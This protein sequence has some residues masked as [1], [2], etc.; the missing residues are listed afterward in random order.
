MRHI[1]SERHTGKRGFTLIELLVVV[2]IIGLLSAVVL[3]S[4]NSA[5]AKARDS[6][7][8]SDLRQMGNLVALMGEAQ[9]FSGCTSAGLASNCTTP[10]FSQFSDPSGG[11]VCGPGNLTAT[12]NYRVSS[13]TGGAPTSANWQVCTY[14]E[15]GAGSL[16]AGAVH[17]G[18]DTSYSVLAGGCAN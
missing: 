18:S 8:M 4:L 3:S 11:S 15:Q 1:L 14:L 17:I 12:C 6:Q 10:D 16:V 7:R 9:A 13:A 2:A 5:R